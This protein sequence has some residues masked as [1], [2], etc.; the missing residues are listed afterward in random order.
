MAASPPTKTVAVDDCHNDRDDEYLLHLQDRHDDHRMNGSP[1]S[2]S[3]LASPPSARMRRRRLPSSSCSS[4]PPKGRRTPAAVLLVV[5][6]LG[7]YK[8]T[9]QNAQLSTMVDKLYDQ[10]ESTQKSHE[11]EAVQRDYDEFKQ[12]DLDG[13]DRVSRTEFDMYVRNHLANYPGMDVADY[14][15]F[16]D[17]DHDG[18]GYV[19]FKEYASQMAIQTQ[20]AERKQ[21]VSEEAERKKKLAAQQALKSLYK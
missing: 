4:S 11:M 12:P 6:L 18:D 8:W 3:P 16:A 15:K 1:A 19:S 5:L 14:P 2:S 20:E 17:F 13:D 21:S 9:E 7:V 10:L